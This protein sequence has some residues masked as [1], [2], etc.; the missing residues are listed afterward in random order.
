MIGFE[1]RKGELRNLLSDF[2]KGIPLS[3]P[4]ELVQLAEKV[5]KQNEAVLETNVSPI[6]KDY[7]EK[8]GIPE[9]AVVGKI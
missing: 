8:N 7:Q 9:H 5:A 3:R 6:A 2:N 4:V 1:R